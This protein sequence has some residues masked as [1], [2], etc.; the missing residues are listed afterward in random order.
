MLFFFKKKVLFCYEYWRPGI[1]L[2]TQPYCLFYENIF[3]VVA[4]AQWWIE[5]MNFSSFVRHQRAHPASQETKVPTL[6]DQGGYHIT[7]PSTDDLNDNQMLW[8]CTAKVRAFEIW[9]HYCMY[10]RTLFSGW[11]LMKHWTSSHVPGIS[12][13]TTGCRVA[14]KLRGSKEQR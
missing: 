13:T 1:A 2:E 11:W 5:R 8:R 6:G 7:S 4:V 12:C 9:L 14:L 10:V 3:C